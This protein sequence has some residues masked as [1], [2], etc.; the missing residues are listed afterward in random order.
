M[1]TS[2]PSRLDDITSDWLTEV[3]RA[4]RAISADARVE[5]FER[6]DLG[7][8]EGFVGDI[9]RLRLAYSA[10]TGPATVIA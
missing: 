7:D 4:E 6:T 5:A 2:T 9:A 1:A 3:L 10:G 8:G